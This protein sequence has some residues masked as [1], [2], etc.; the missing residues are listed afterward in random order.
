MDNKSFIEFSPINVRKNYMVTGT[1]PKSI[2]KHSSSGFFNSNKKVNQNFLNSKLFILNKN[3]LETT[4]THKNYNLA[5]L[6]K[7]N[8]FES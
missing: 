6:R 4:F 7:K 3:H 8:L 2:S 5:K 1:R